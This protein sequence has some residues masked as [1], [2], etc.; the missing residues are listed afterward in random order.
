M[1]SCDDIKNQMPQP[2]LC[3]ARQHRSSTKPSGIQRHISRNDF[4]H[5]FC[6]SEKVKMKTILAYV[7]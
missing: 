5:Y 3:E 2:F 7:V 4:K 1:L 6:P